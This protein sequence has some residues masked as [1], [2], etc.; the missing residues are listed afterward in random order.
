MATSTSKS[1]ASTRP[2]SARRSTRSWSTTSS[3][4]PTTSTRRTSRSDSTRWKA[5]TRN[6]CRWSRT[7]TGR[8]SGCSAPP[9]RRR[10]PT[11]TRSARCAMRDI[12]STR[13]AASD[14]SWAAR[15]TRSANSAA[16]SPPMA[17][18]L[19]RS[20]LKSPAST[21]AGPYSCAR[22]ATGTS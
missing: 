13:R 21:A 1:A 8:C 4:S 5:G 9:R 2:A 12:S 18:L 7:S 15:A 16:R 19:S 22:A 11:P 10:R 3:R 20:F 17:R 6:G 14:R